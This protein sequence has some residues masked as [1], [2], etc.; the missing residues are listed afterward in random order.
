M[1]RGINSHHIVGR[2]GQDP[3]L[4]E[5]AKGHPV[6]NFSVATNDGNR[7]TWHRVVAWNQAAEFAGR[8]LKRGDLVYVE[9]AVEHREYMQG[10]Q[11]RVSVEIY[12][13]VVQSL[14]SADRVPDG[15]TTPPRDYPDDGAPF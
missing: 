14:E 7:V 9:G 5:T 10:D 11:K 2:L 1:A 3:D 12:A 6:C 13:R 8:Y 15:N 4:R